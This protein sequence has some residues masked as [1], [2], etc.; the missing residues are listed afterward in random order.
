MSLSSSWVGSRIALRQH[1]EPVGGASILALVTYDALTMHAVRDELERRVLGGHVDRAVLIDTRRVALEVFAHGMRLSVIFALDAGESRIFLSED[2][3]RRATERVSPFSLLLRK[4]VAG[5]EI[6][7]IEQPRLERLMAFQLVSRVEKA[8][9]RRIS[10]VA[11]AMG[12]RSNLTL[13]DE[14]GTVMDALVRA[15]PST[16]PSR[17]ILPH[18]R[19]VAPPRETKLDPLDDHV[20]RSLEDETRRHPEMAASD[21][22][23]RGIAG[24]SPLAAREALARV[25]AATDATASAVASWTDVVDALRILV[26]SVETRMWEPCVAQRE[27]LPID[28]APYRLTQFRAA[29]VVAFDSISEAIRAVEARPVS[30]RPFDL[31]KQPL[32]RALEER[33]EQARRKRSS[34]ERTLAEAG[35]AE[36]LREAGEAI[37][38]SAH[39]LEPLASALDWNGR[40]IDLYPTLSPAENA[41]SYFRR[42]ANARDARKV[43]PPLLARA[44]AELEHLDELALHV[45]LAASQ[46]D[47]AALRAELQMAGILRDHAQPR[48][49]RRDKAKASSGLYRTV[50]VHTAQVLVGASALGNETVTF[51]LAKP[52]DLWFHAR[53]VPGAHVVLRTHGSAP[54]DDQVSAAAGLAAAHSAA[55]DATRVEVDYTRRKYVRKARGGPP[56]RVTY[57]KESTISVAPADGV[58]RSRD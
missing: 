11:E 30:A 27:G 43:V 1:P 46:S 35:V 51:R 36:E 15:P 22:L 42:Y 29:E 48:S 4:Y 6:A 25:A 37:L 20:V 13:V 58:A 16:N 8:P 38:A 31:L 19:Y 54:G 2:R 32:L 47:I 52:D 9:P 3:A 56:G 21:L 34:L 14:D 5:A 18:L 28:Y 12:R 26:A 50:S 44:E 33:A 45:R 39:A 23:V 49:P 17:P 57:A 55:R 7:A 24:C 53:G 40:R 10:L 41:Q